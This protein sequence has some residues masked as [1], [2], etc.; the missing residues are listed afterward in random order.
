[1]RPVV[2]VVTN[3]RQIRTTPNSPLTT[4]HFYDIGYQ[5]NGGFFIAVLNTGM[6]HV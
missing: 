1:M 5:F 2:G 3:Q 4:H 6:N